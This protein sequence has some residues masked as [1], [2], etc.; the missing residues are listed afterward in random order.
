MDGR[1][2]V[3]S[4]LDDGYQRRCDHRSDQSKLLNH[5]TSFADP[6]LPFVVHQLEME[7]PK[8]LWLKTHMKPEL[9]ARCNFFDLPDYRQRS[10]SRFLTHLGLG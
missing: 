3:A 9:F 7:I 2:R 10:F 4:P 8:T 6:P 5:L 1:A